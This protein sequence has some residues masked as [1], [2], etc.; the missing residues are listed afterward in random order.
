VAGGERDTGGT[1]VV[2]FGDLDGDGRA[3]YVTREE[4][5]PGEDAGMRQELRHAKR[6][7]AVWRLHRSRADLSM[8]AAPFQEVE[9]EGYALS[10]TERDGIDDDEDGIAVSLPDTGLRDLN[11]DGRLDLVAL[12]LDFS[13]LQAVK[14]LTVRRIGIGIDFRVHCQEPGGRFA[15]V[16]G[17]DL[18]GKL[19]LDLDHLM[20]RH[21]SQFRGD[22]DGD[23]V[24]DFA[25][26]GRGR[27]VT[28]HRGGTDCSYAV[29]P[30]LVLEL[31]AEPA[32]HALVQIRDLDGDA[33]SDL[34]VIQPQPVEEAGTTPPVRL[35]LYSSSGRSDS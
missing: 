9:V 23:G 26:I 19:S 13:L 6:P 10:D 5:G 17:L 18:S 32:N 31:R 11:G 27:T 28:I 2:H 22:F 14:V 30:D 35:D 1:G 34:L 12:T 15:A 16:P 20:V 29:E 25:Q 4:R 8:E 3:E 33:R 24:A 21:L 7:R